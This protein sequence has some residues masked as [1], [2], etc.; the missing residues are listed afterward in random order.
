MQNRTG[1]GSP[2]VEAGAPAVEAAGLIFVSLLTGR[3]ADGRLAG[4]D[5]AS[6]ATAVLARMRRVLEDA[7][8][9]LEQAVAIN[10]FLKRASDFESMNNAYRAI[11]SDRPPTRTTVVADLGPDV[12]VGMSAVAVPRGAAR[13]VMHPAGW[14]KSPRPYSTIVRTRD[15]VFLSGLISRRGTDDQVLPGSAGFQTTTILNNAA[16]LLKTA[17]VTVADVVASRVYVTDST[18]FAEMNDAYRQVF[19]TAP[20]ARATAVAGLMGADY[21]VEITL[22]AARGRREILGPT[23]APSLPLSTAVRSGGLVFLSGVLG[24][25]DANI[26]DV[27]GQTREVLTRI[28]RT[29]ASAGLAFADVVDNTVYLTDV[30]QAHVVNQAAVEFFGSH[31]PAQT[32]MG[33]SLVAR[34][35][36]V[37][38][39]MIAAERR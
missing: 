18:Y 2:V 30:W 7:G 1:V 33:A 13:D 36:L 9:S 5:V 21:K 37:E 8:S 12:L 34:A 23:V 17:G 14:M 3:G 4:E 28:G 19:A 16:E 10:V 22:I 25:T 15:F 39:M 35:G 11:L 6:Q 31:K 27:A 26:G 32:T 20:P 24:N 38:M 29:L